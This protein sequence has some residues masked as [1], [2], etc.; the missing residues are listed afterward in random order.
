MNAMNTVNKKHF[1]RLFT[2]SKSR[3]LP[4]RKL[5]GQVLSTKGGGKNSASPSSQAVSTSVMLF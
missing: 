5:N 4:R 2:F 3:R 1:P